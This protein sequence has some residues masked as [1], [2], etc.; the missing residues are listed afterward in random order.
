M[1][2]PQD[3]CAQNLA[4]P[5]IWHHEAVT[6]QPSLES[7]RA[8]AAVVAEAVGVTEAQVEQFGSLTLDI[9]SDLWVSAA[10]AAAS[11]GA[12]Y[13]D[14]LTVVDFTDAL[15]VVAH[16][17]DP[18]QPTRRILLRAGADPDGIDTLTTVFPGAAWHER[19]AY[20]MFGVIFRGHPDLRR[21]LLPPE[22]TINPLRR[23]FVLAARLAKPWPGAADPSDKPAS[24]PT[25]GSGVARKAS[26]SRRKTL[27]PGVPEGWLRDAETAKEHDV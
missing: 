17:V 16:L 4:F 1:S 2:T 18:S 11:N 8:L 27:P 26:P 20:E 10:Q 24:T 3:S 19:E 15:N 12:T 14:F 21:L 9:A 25:G 6:V 23:D 7:A 5:G 13:L 22:S